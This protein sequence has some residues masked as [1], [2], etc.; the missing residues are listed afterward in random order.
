[1]FNRTADLTETVPALPDLAIAVK[2][3]T[4]IYPASGRREKVVALDHVALDV[5]RGAVFGLLGPNGA[6]KSTLINILAGLATKT[7][8]RATLWGLDLD[9]EPRRAAS[10]IGVVPQELTFDSFFS[11]REVLEQQA[12]LYGLP[13]RA[14]RTEHLLDMLELTEVENASVRALSGGMKR[15][16]MVAKAM[17]HSPP[18]LILDEP[19]AGVDVELRHA[20][21]QHIRDLKAGGATI[22]L[23]THYLEEAQAL[24]DNI[25]ILHQGRLVANDT[26]DNLLHRLDNKSFVVTVD[27][28]LHDVPPNLRPHGWLLEGKRRL[29]LPS[30]PET[31]SLGQMLLSVQVN[32]LNIVDI[33]T[34]ETNL[35]DVFLDMTKGE[36]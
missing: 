2:G 8:G 15:R 33:I 4:K 18:I 28:D 7:S 23:T 11:P 1:M 32:G 14:R 17:V 25:A 31:G 21:W 5:P 35:E 3:L 29:R 24:C 6:G 34:Q 16:L 19:T 9:R 10:V 20:L 36:P 22:L 30:R 26:K 27:R 12:G 13:P